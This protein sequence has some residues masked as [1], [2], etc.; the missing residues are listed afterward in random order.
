MHRRS[1]NGHDRFPRNRVAGGRGGHFGGSRDES[2]EQRT[3]REASS[4]KIIDHGLDN[5]SW[6]AHDGL[7]EVAKIHALVQRFGPEAGCAPERYRGAMDS[8]R[9]GPSEREVAKLHKLIPGLALIGT[10]SED[11]VG[12][13]DG[14]HKNPYEVL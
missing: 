5:R 8:R 3:Q 9:L 12:R 13:R 1:M 11:G 7:A 2:P 4:A 10:V 6:G 14:S